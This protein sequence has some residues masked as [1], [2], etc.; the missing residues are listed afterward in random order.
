LG[1]EQ[2]EQLTSDE[3]FG[4]AEEE[5]EKAVERIA[6]IIGEN[7]AGGDVALENALEWAI[8]E[9]AQAMVDVRAE[10]LRD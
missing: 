4:I 9:G 7:V 6:R 2:A 10:R 5:E 3:A 8:L 1:I